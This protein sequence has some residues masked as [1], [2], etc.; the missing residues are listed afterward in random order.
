MGLIPGGPHEGRSV[1]DR[2]SSMGRILLSGEGVPWCTKMGQ[3]IGK[4]GAT[5]KGI[6]RE[7]PA[8]PTDEMARKPMRGIFSR[9]P[10]FLAVRRQRVRAVFTTQRPCSHVPAIVNSAAMDMYLFEL[11]FSLGIC[12]VMGLLGHMI[13]LFLFS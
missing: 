4:F 11:Q 9:M 12:P 2:L 5:E 1:R 6:R 7:N 8:M 10:S 13:V 3:G